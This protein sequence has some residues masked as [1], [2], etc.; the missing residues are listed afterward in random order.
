MTDKE[1]RAH[2]YAK[3]LLAS[4]HSFDGSDILSVSGK[5]AESYLINKHMNSAY[6]LGCL[7]G[8]LKQQQKIDELESK[9]SQLSKTMTEYYSGSFDTIG[10]L[11]G[12][13][14]T[15]LSGED[16]D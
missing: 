6:E 7:D 3:I 15:I 1:K 10:E 14:S 9:I 5:G 12:E 8:K 16:H 13:I 2:D 11:A 4:D